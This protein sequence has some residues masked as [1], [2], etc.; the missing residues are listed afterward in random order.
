MNK[1]QNIYDRP[2]FF[3]GYKTL[4]DDPYCCNMIEE[5]P[6][7]FSIIPD[8]QGKRVLDLGCGF[9]ENCAEFA[10]LG[11]DRVTGVD[12]SEKMLNAAAGEN[13]DMEFV[14]G[15]MSDLSFI[16]D[17]YD[18]V[19]SS[20]AVHYLEDFEKF[21]GEVYSILAPGGYLVFSQEHPINTSGLSGGS[22]GR[23][24]N[25]QITHFRLDNYMVSGIRRVDW[26]VDGIEKYHRTFSEIINAL[27]NAGFAIEKVLEPM[28]DEE[29]SKGDP[30]REERAQRRRHKPIFLLIRA[31]KA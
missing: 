4:R 8:L 24:E 6:A 9:G 26:F 12:I 10:R 11:A 5:K 21:A 25:G 14:R 16:N 22:F 1:S 2:E 27:I 3:D 23:D 31:R 17:K 28:P 29:L 18:V 13:P 20:L 15:D 19:T 30:N 7:I